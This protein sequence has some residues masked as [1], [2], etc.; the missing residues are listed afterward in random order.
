MKYHNQMKIFK[1]NRMKSG[2]SQSQLSS[3]LNL[4]TKMISAIENGR[5]KIPVKKIRKI[6]NLL[7]VSSGD[8]LAAISIDNMNQLTGEFYND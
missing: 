4:S 6:S 2:L 5:R 7:D 8:V 3:K 1:E